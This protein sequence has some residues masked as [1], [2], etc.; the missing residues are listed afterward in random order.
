[1]EHREEI[2]RCPGCG[3]AMKVELLY[4]AYPKHA[5]QCRCECGWSGPKAFAESVEAAAIQ[6]KEAA[7]VRK[8]RKEAAPCM[9]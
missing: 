2:V 3:K 8:G 4:I 1:M 6:A 9:T 7:R 5:A